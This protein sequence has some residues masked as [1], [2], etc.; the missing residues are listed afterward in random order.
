M[1]YLRIARYSL[2]AAIP[3]VLAAVLFTIATNGVTP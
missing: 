2:V 1:S 3:T